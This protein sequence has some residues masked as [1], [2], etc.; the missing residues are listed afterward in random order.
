[1]YFA[2]FINEMAQ[3][4][5]Q[6]RLDQLFLTSFRLHLFLII[7]F[8][9]HFQ[10]YICLSCLFCEVRMPQ[11]RLREMALDEHVGGRS[12]LVSCHLIFLL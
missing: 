5:H 12:L 4:L 6:I 7:V 1:M 9:V 3:T 2:S 8:E 11:A 10:S